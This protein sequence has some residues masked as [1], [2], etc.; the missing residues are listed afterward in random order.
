MI[1]DEQTATDPV[2]L[3]LE[4]P[5]ADQDLRLA[6]GLGIAG[7]APQVLALGARLIG[8]DGID[9]A[10]AALV[11]GSLILSFIGGSWWGMALLRTEGRWRAILLLLGIAASLA[12]FCIL[13]LA[14]PE[15]LRPLL[16]VLGVLIGASCLVDRALVEDEVIGAW[17]GELRM[18][19]SAGLG[20]LTV[21]MGLLS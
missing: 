21:V 2:A 7:L 6:I 14:G 11:Y 9:H 16:I 8:V 20:L 4:A 1:D 5:E 19:L 17:W 13:G 10:Q 15:T 3:E 12:G 18:A